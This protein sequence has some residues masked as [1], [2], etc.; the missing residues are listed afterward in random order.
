MSAFHGSPCWY[1]LASPSATVEAF[2]A[3]LLGWSWAEAGA[4]GLPYRIASLQGSGVAGMM[5]ARP[6]QPTGWS[7][8]V[9]VDDCAATLARA[10]ALGAVVCMGVTEIPGAGQFASLRDPQGATF[11]LLQPLP[12]AQGSAFDQ[13]RP[14]HGHWHDL[15]TPDPEAALEFYM[16]LFGWTVPRSMA[17]GPGMTYH[18][19]ARAGVDI[20]G[21][22]AMPGAAPFWKPYFGVP[23]ITAAAR[24]V[25]FAGGAVLRGPDPVP[26]GLLTL[27]I[28]D[29]EGSALALVGPA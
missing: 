7:I 23:S 10:E 28:A 22:F 29:P 12:G 15:V 3:S 16:D 19:I 25:T 27:Q 20:G 2:Y 4:P 1:E 11:N 6:G 24:T 26:G 18:L 14:G 17:M 8:Y 5:Q 9:A 21:T 13:S